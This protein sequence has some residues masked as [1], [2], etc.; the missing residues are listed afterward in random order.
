[1]ATRLFSRSVRLTR[2]ALTTLKKV[3]MSPSRG[4]LASLTPTATILEMASQPAGKGDAGYHGD[5][6]AIAP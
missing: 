2:T 3:V 1:M 6:L 5:G 4:H